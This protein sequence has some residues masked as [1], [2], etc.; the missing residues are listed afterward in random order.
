MCQI[1]FMSEMQKKIK[2][3]GIFKNQTLLSEQN[4][5]TML[6]Q[7]DMTSYNSWFLTEYHGVD[8]ILY[9]GESSKAPLNIPNLKE[10]LEKIGNP[11]N[12]IITFSTKD[13][14]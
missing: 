7:D 10:G 1:K 4:G 6:H 5:K 12:V 13:V 3:L 2:E 11:K 9:R 14:Y 8:K